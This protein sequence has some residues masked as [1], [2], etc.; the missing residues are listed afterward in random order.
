MEINCTTLY[1][2]QKD[3]KSLPEQTNGVHILVEGKVKILNPYDNFTM[4]TLSKKEC[5]GLHKYLLDKSFEYYG[6][7]YAMSRQVTTNPKDKSIII[8]NE[9]ATTLFL[10]ENKLYLIPFYD[11]KT[12]KAESDKRKDLEELNKLAEKRYHFEAS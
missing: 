8:E 10:G 9:I 5:Y 11:L 1:T 6:D 4:K 2:Y 7:I 3:L 12:I